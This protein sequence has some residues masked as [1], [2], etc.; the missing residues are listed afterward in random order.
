MFGTYTRFILGVGPVKLTGKVNLRARDMCMTGPRPMCGGR[1]CARSET[2]C[3]MHG[4]SETIRKI[5]TLRTFDS[6]QQD[7]LLQIR[8]C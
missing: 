1:V 2:Y 8:E 4:D 5:N 3:R 7:I 6:Q